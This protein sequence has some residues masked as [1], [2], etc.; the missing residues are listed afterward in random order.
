MAD[1]TRR[2]LVA[3]N[4][5]MN[6]SSQFATEFAHAW[7]AQAKATDNVDVVFFPPWAYLQLVV[8][9]LGPSGVA[10]GVQNVSPEPSGAFT[11]ECAA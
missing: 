4:W 5:K 2:A 10:F 7:S 9:A 8:S 1:P 6:G 11:G 3:A